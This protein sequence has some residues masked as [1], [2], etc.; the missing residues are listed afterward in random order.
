MT[1]VLLCSPDLYYSYVYWLVLFISEFSEKGAEKLHTVKGRSY[2]KIPFARYDFIT[3]LHWKKRKRF[4]KIG[5]R[6]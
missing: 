6:L 2:T 5:D 4:K 3:S 1:K